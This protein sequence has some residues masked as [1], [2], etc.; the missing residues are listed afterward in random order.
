[1]AF[2]VEGLSDHHEPEI[3]VRRIGEY[4]SIEDAVS[5][6]KRLIDVF[7]RNHFRPGMQAKALLTRYQ[8][9]GEHPYI[10]RD[11][12][13]T[14][15]VPSFNHLHYATTRSADICSGRKK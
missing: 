3:K 13:K 4:E 15:N 6:S 9:K 7:L 14:F 11:D 12:D 2:F 1:M 8:D 10:F 5:S